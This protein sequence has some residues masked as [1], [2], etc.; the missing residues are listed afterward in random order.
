[1]L[2]GAIFDGKNGKI[3]RYF[4]LLEKWVK[5]FEILLMRAKDVSERDC[6]KRISY[7]SYCILKRFCIFAEK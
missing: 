6:P 4:L 7:K 2:Y 5:K 1:M 3:A